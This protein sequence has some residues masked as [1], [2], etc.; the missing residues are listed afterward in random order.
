MPQGPL[1]NFLWGLFHLILCSFSS[2]IVSLW[3]KLGQHSY[4][5][6]FLV[7]CSYAFI[8]ITS[9]CPEVNQAY[10]LICQECPVGTY[11]DVDGSGVDLC[12]PCSMD[13]LPN[14]ANF[15]YVRG[16]FDVAIC[17]YMHNSLSLSDNCDDPMQVELGTSPVLINVFLTNIGCPTVIQL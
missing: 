8:C 16:I 6:L 2:Y 4:C 9:L 10:P 12:I 7:I 11:K 1:W 13:L 5:L 3:T 17:F 15:I 14:R